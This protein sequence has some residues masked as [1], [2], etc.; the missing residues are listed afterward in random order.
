MS[1]QNVGNIEVGRAQVWLAPV[2][3]AY[4][5]VG[6]TPS[7]SWNLAPFTETGWTISDSEKRNPITPDE[8][9]DAVANPLMTRTTILT[10]VFYQGDLTA[11]TYVRGGT[12]TAVSGTPNY[13]TFVPQVPG[14]SD[15]V[16]AFLIRGVGPTVGGVQKTHDLQVF[17]G[18]PQGDVKPLY[19]KG[20]PRM[21][22]GEWLALDPT[23]Q[24]YT[25]EIFETT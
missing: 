12:L 10:A 18:S 2:G 6:G 25:Y 13:Q 9:F 17:A 11:M 20:K 19:A 23:G 3:T 7:A 15:P 4:P 14:A 24:G 1:D 21:L 16:W 22:Q 8:L 5:A